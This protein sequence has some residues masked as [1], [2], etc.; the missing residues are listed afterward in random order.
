MGLVEPT[1]IACST[2]E[3]HPNGV[4]PSPISWA[5]SASASLRCY[6]VGSASPIADTDMVLLADM[7]ATSNLTFASSSLRCSMLSLGSKTALNFLINFSLT[8][9]P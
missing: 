8:L 2:H 9:V 4:R 1:S 6:S 3:V 5:T 7:E